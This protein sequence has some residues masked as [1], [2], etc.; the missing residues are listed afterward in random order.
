[1]TSAVIVF[2]DVTAQ[3]TL[4]QHKSDFLSV[5]NHELRT[6]IFTIQGYVETLLGGAVEDPAVNKK[7]LGS[8]AKSIDRLVELVNDLDQ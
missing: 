4:E 5:A 3:K 2:Q 6:P 8:T 7:F 1:M